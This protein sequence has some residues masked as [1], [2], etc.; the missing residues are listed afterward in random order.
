MVFIQH[1]AVKFQLIRVCKLIDV[2]LIQSAGFGVI[3][4]AVGDCNP[5][6]SVL[7]VKILGEVGIGHEMPAEKLNGFHRRLVVRSNA[8]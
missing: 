7:L 5:T 8:A 3:P 6:R 2:L 1:H 4:Q